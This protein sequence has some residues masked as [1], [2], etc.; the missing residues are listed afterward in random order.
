MLNVYIKEDFYLILVINLIGHN[1]QVRVALIKNKYNCNFSSQII[2][3]DIKRLINQLWKLIPM[4]EKEEDW[5]QQLENVIIEICGLNE[6]LNN[7]LNLLILLSKL[8]GLKLNPNI[9]FMIY[10]KTVFRCIDLLAKAADNI[11]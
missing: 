8:E 4:K 10:R 6:I 1:W 5:K 7:K 9:D 2:Q 11:E 3:A